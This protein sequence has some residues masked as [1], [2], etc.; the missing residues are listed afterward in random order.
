MN[1]I[2]LAELLKETADK[3][4]EMENKKTEKDFEIGKAEKLLSIRDRTVYKE[5]EHVRLLISKNNNDIQTLCEYAKNEILEGHNL[6]ME[7]IDNSFKEIGVT[8]DKI[9]ES[10]KIIDNLH[11]V[12]HD[13]KMLNE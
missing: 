4:V 7:S 8:L 6:N 9:K 5:L 13:L 2:E 10:K 11:N 12:D 1:N 3:L